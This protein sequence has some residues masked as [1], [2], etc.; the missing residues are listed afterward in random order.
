MKRIYTILIL[1]LLST[2]SVWSQTPAF[3][4]LKEMDKRI[5]K[6]MARKRIENGLDQIYNQ[7]IAEDTDEFFFRTIV[8]NATNPNSNQVFYQDNVRILNDYN[9]VKYGQTDEVK[10]YFND[11]IF[12][13]RNTPNSK[14]EFEVE[15]VGD[16]VQGSY[17][18]IELDYRLKFD[19]YFENRINRKGKNIDVQKI[20]Y[21]EQHLRAELRADKIGTKWEVFIT[22]IAANSSYKPTMVLTPTKKPVEPKV[23]TPKKEATTVAGKKPESIPPKTQEPQPKTTEQPVVTKTEVEPPKTEP[24]PETKPAVVQNTAKPKNDFKQAKSNVSASPLPKIVVAVAG[25]GA[26]AYGYMLNSSFSSAKSE[27]ETISATQTTATAEYNAAYDKALAAQSK[28]GLFTAMLGVAGVA[29]IVEGYLLLKPN[30]KVES[31]FKI[32]PASTGIGVGI[33][34]KF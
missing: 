27:L 25:L 31:N 16:V 9:P 17:L 6:D 5:I 3:K 29:T 32:E 20:P 13:K 11:F 24:K 18:Y 12:I 10:S 7:L 1:C 14:F 15:R 34:Y 33:K 2:L 22:R 8:A 21:K 28:K 19:G 30:G 26:G 23:E 4:D